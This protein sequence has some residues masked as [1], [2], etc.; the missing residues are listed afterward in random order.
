M[1]PNKPNIY[2][3]IGIVI[4]IIIIASTIPISKNI[5]IVTTVSISYPL[6][7]SDPKIID[8]NTKITANT[9]FHLPDISSASILPSKSDVKIKVIG[10]GVTATK[11]VGTLY[12]GEGTVT[13]N[14]TYKIVLPGVHPSTNVIIVELY[15]GDT[16][17][18][19][20]EV[21]LS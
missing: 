1:N 4:G 6:I 13:E 18:D 7:L 3:I 10:G 21:K 11:S 20:K 5:D 14:P 16:K 12:R 17:L 8:V 19:S 15:S 9:L 2:A